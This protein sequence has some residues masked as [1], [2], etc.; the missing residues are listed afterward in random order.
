LRGAEEVVLAAGRAFG[1]GLEAIGR[2][3]DELLAGRRAVVGIFG[4]QHCVPLLH[5]RGQAGVLVAGAVQTR[6]GFGDAGDDLAAAGAP[7]GSGVGVGGA[8]G[9]GVEGRHAVGGAVGPDHPGQRLAGMAL[10]EL[11]EFGGGVLA[12]EEVA[13]EFWGEAWPHRD[14]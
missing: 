4:G 9:G 10:E 13:G 14:A 8:E 11:G 12:F 2:E 5:G 6:Q 3:Q 7:D 1:L